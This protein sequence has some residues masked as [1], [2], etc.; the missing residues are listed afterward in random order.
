M[1][2]RMQARTA[3]DLKR[4][5]SEALKKFGLEFETA[6][7]Y[8]TPRR[9][10]LV[11]D[12]LPTAQP[13]ISE[14]RKGPKA[15][16]P[17][18]AIAGFLKSVGLTRDQVEERETPK[19]T[20]LFAVIEKKGAATADVLADLLPE[21][22]AKLPW[23]KSMRWGDRPDRWVR[24]LRGVLCL[25][26]G[27]LVSF[28]YNHL[29]SRD[30]TAG[31]RFM[32]PDAITV[33]GFA[34][35]QDKLRHAYVMLDAAERR[36][37]IEKDAAMAAEGE[38][39]SLKP[40]PGL[41]AEVAGLVEWP[42]VLTGAIDPDFMDLPAEVLTTSMRHHLKHFA[43]L[44]SDG[45]L[46]PRF[47]VVANNHATDGGKQIV[48]GNER[49][50]RAR[51]SDAK[52]FWDRDRKQTLES[53]I[54]E[55]DKVVFHAKL[56]SVGDK[57]KRIEAL[58]VEIAKSIPG[59]EKAAV[60]EGARLCKADL[61]SGMVV[62]FPELQGVMGRYYALAEGKDAAVSDAI[63]EHYSPQGPNDD[64]PSSPASIAVALAD[65]ID[66][67]AGFWAIDEK[68]TGSKDPFAL[69][70]AALGAI[71]LIVE[72]DLRVSLVNVF[73]DALR[74]YAV[75]MVEADKPPQID[76][77]DILEFFADRLKVHLRE[78]GVRHDLISAVFALG[79]E[80][81]LVRLLARVEA[82]QAFVDSDDGEHLLTAYKRA[83]NIVGIEE[84]KDGAS[85]DD[86]EVD[87]AL[88]SEVDEIAVAERLTEVGDLADAALA[89]EEFAAAMSDLA[90]L[91][92]PV[93]NF[94]DNVTVNCDDAD[95]RRNRL[96]LLAGIR[97]TLDRVADFSK[98][99]G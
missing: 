10:A 70:R 54:P 79:G 99:E 42:V 52:F 93:D 53:R 26:D 21:A 81:D 89:N 29:E 55:L 63:A 46:A 37:V 3:D 12:G 88:L 62:E 7:A 8:A 25:F 60:Q 5:V 72:N 48:A 96:S 31:H 17:D 90:L 66:S 22:V 6:E 64:C 87:A 69:R 40:D 68:P 76:A 56:G 33:A 35:Y 45:N 50:L 47:V 58:A 9:L 39:F 91:R 59:A 43:L 61:V 97:A 82:L 73:Y 2:A 57:V 36:T 13:D 71:R 19:G 78:K 98:I 24:P 94:F 65:K 4:L 41:V 16:A 92:K 95:L 80:D 28:A 77:N 51:L 11:V 18:Q 30:T 44:D 14:E 15:D 67:L 38:G 1:A 32:A 75:A 84:K 27:A 20:V 85:Y 74:S 83:A 49:V 86:A 23:P 34:D